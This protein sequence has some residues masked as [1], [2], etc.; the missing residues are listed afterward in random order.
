M[1]VATMACATSYGALQRGPGFLWTSL[2]THAIPGAAGAQNQNLD[3]APAA[4]YALADFK[5]VEV[6]H[7]EL[8]DDCSRLAARVQLVGRLQPVACEFDFEALEFEHPPKRIAYSSVVID[9]Q[10]PHRPHSEQRPFV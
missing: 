3:I 9:D 4:A 6:G 7:G 10:D 8:E 2:P 1:I 5:P